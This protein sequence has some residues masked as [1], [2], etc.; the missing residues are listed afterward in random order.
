[1]WNEINNSGGTCFMKSSVVTTVV[2]GFR[3]A[4]IITFNRYIFSDTDFVPFKATD[5]LMEDESDGP[6]LG[7]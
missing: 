2:N 4:E 3:K 5:I 1:M 7:F 6:F